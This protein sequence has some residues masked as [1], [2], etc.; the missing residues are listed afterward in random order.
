MYAKLSA[1]D[2]DGLQ[3]KISI[4]NRAETYNVS[5]L[6]K[7]SNGYYILYFRNILATEFDSTVTAVFLRNGVQVGQTMTYSVN[8]Y[9]Y[10]AQNSSNTLLANLMQATY[11]YGAS[12][13][14]YSL[15]H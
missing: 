3:V 9:V 14:E 8:S 15:N 1:A 2:L 6:E 11:N 7:D 10:T 5:D 13:Y 12:A 4:G